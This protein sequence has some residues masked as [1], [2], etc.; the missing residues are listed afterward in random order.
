MK[1]LQILCVFLTFFLIPQIMEAQI[2]SEAVP[3]DSTQIVEIE[4]NNGSVLRGSILSVSKDELELKQQDGRTFI[5][6]SRIRAIHRIDMNRKGARWFPNP[7]YSRLFFSPTAR[8]LQKNSGYY[9]NIYVFFNSF[10]YA[11]TDHIAFTAGFS[12]IPAVQMQ[13]QLYFASVKAGYEISDGHFLGTGLGA[14]TAY[15]MEDGL[16]NGFINYT[17]EFHNSNVTAGITGLSTSDEIGPYAVYLGGSYR[18]IERVAFVTENYVFPN[19]ENSYLL[20]LGVRL[21]GENVSFDLALFR[22]GLGADV[23]VGIPYIDFVFN[24]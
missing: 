14:A 6:L 5:R 15:A 7:N 17:R 13:N 2:E 16:I 10:S 23:S 19:A 24:F 3:V 12:L 1:S 4:L 9:Q 20:S 18:I 11:V 22:P 21:M 8:P